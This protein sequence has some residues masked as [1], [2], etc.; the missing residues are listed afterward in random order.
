MTYGSGSYGSDAYASES[1]TEPDAP[2]EGTATPSQGWHVEIIHP[3]SGRVRTPDV[4]NSPALN[5]GPNAQP[6]LR[7]PVSKDTSW[8]SDG[9][10]DDAEMRVWKDGDRVPVEVLRDVEQEEDR[11]V[12]V[13]VG[14]VELE[15]RTR[16][17]YN[18]DRRHVEAANLVTGETDY[19]VDAPEPSPSLVEDQLQRSVDTDA[20]FAD[21]LN[22][23]PTDPFVIENGVLRPAQTSFSIEGETDA[24]NTLTEGVQ[25]SDGEA[26]GLGSSFAS[27]GDAGQYSFTTEHDIEEWDLRWRRAII[28]ESD[29]DDITYLPGFDVRVDGTVVESFNDGASFSPASGFVDPEWEIINAFSDDFTLSGSTTVEIE[30]TEAS[31]DFS[32]VDPD[33][34]GELVVDVINVVDTQVPHTFDKKVHEDN[35]YLDEPQDYAPATVETGNVQSP[36]NIVGARSD[37]TINDFSGAQRVQISN[38]GGSTYLPD[39]GSENN[40]DAVTVDS[41][42][43][44]GST[45]RQRFRLEGY[46]PG[47]PQ[48][49]TPRLGYAAQ[50]IDAYDLFS[51]VSLE[52]L[53]IEETFDNNLASI[54]SDFAEPAERSWAFRY[55]DGTPTVQFVENGQRVADF[56]PEVDSRTRKKLGKTY[57]SVTIKG[58][59]EPVSREPYTAS[60]TFK[61]LVR[62]NILPGSETVVD[63]A[64]G[65]NYRRGDDYEINYQP[66]ELRATDSGRLS[67]GND[68][69]VNYQY[70]ARG[71]F[72]QPD[73]PAEPDELVEVV[74]GVTSE[75][76]GEQ[77]A[78]VIFDDVETPRFAADVTIPDPDPRFNPTEALPPDALGLPDAAG[79]LEVR[80]EPELTERGLRVRFGTRPAVERSIQRISR[81]LSRVSD[82]S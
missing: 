78:F 52:L 14:G 1:Q 6:R 24:I 13:G 37:L 49:A 54:L 7:L 21:A 80:G 11:T 63:P 74:P 33:D 46:E 23:Q 81:Q 48:S 57:D 20:E 18:N 82:R 26:T 59:N 50:E 9:Y 73:A 19:A 75:R 62:E 42:P 34:Y 79:S 58:S 72:E 39:D 47:G 10:D 67:V 17:E 60:T 40:T 22:L 12:L 66:G 76:L 65:E 45:L 32:T 35:G 70:Q 30:I 64:T 16:R 69:E 68:F 51:D 4:L 53:L 27:V 28:P 31:F 61:S 5:P 15:Q 43:D 2:A 29:T 3:T 8:L 55:V 56:E 44:D 77:V 36:F 41:F 25:Y 71:T 38:D